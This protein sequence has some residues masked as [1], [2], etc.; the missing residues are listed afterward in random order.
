[1]KEERQHMN[2]KPMNKR[3]FTLVELLVVIA[4]IALLVGLLLPAL[5]KAMSAA[6]T[7][8]DS[9]QM[10]QI[11]QSMLSM[12]QETKGGKMPTPG[13][14]NRVGTVPG[15]GIEN[16]AENRTQ[17]LYSACVARNLFNT[18]LIV[19]PTEV[20]PQIT[21]YQ[22]YNYDLYR[23]ANDTYWDTGFTAN[24]A[25]APGSAT[26]SNTSYAH[27]VLAGYRKDHQWRNHLD[28]TKPH[29]VTRGTNNGVTAGANYEQS[30]T[31]R[32]HG[33]QKSWAGNICFADNHMEYIETFTPENVSFECGTG[34]LTKDN[35]FVNDPAFT[36]GACVPRNAAGNPQT[37]AGGDAWLGIHPNT[38]TQYLC[39][40]VYD[41]NTP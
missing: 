26:G 17:W 31:L 39:L 3:G 23:P 38:A 24:V 29:F 7:V 6:K 21:V 27:L 25:A 36:Q 12:A 30:P 9:T 10:K 16:Y 14:I 5:A 40:P 18:D 4:I 19:G 32:L 2:T 28:S 33:P 34:N 8:K 35:I 1:M 37:F 11:H 41:P 22:N 13:L 20:N 15:S